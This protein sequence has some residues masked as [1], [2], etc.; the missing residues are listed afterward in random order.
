MKIVRLAVVSL[1]LACVAS[2]VSA[3]TSRYELSLAAGVSQFDA[4]GTGTAPIAAIR[5]SGPIVGSW[6][7]GD[8]SLSYASLD[9]QFSTVNTRAGVAEG[10]VQVQWPVTRFRPYIG[11][12][13]GWQHY[14]NNDA[15]RGATAQTASGS[16]GLRVAVSPVLLLR[17]ELRLRTWNSRNSGFHNS[18][19]EFT[20]GLGFAF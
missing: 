13:G 1:L 4:S 20:A 11:I 19:A 16:V 2:P 6:L 15:G 5:M 14:F 10:Q 8:L 17:G 3:Q 12:G 9:E 7:L 18:A